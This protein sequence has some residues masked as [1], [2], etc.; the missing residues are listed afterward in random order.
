[1]DAVHIFANIDPQFN[2]ALEVL[3]ELN[4]QGRLEI[5][6]VQRAWLD[7]SIQSNN[8]N[9]ANRFIFGGHHA[10]NNGQSAAAFG[11]TASAVFRM[12]MLRAVQMQ[13]NVWPALRANSKR[14]NKA[15]LQFEVVFSALANNEPFML[16]ENPVVNTAR[17]Y[18][19]RYD[20]VFPHFLI[21][22]EVLENVGNPVYFNN[23]MLIFRNEFTEVIEITTNANATMNPP[24]TENGT[25]DSYVHVLCTRR[26]IKNKQ[27]DI[28]GGKFETMKKLIKP[29][30]ISKDHIDNVLEKFKKRDGDDDWQKKFN[31][32]TL[33]E[34]DSQ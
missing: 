21:Q 11:Q 29:V 4:N 10:L 20:H 27:E 31:K 34:D 13:E 19:S 22:S 5:T 25:F 8:D 15:S 12:V 14:R 9:D 24:K 28:K 18:W 32:M 30:K 23:M 3:R 6:N 7:E 26:K 17:M 33:S 2:I 1:M 16:L